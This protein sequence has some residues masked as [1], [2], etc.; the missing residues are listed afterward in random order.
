MSV[1]RR[2]A[3][4]NRLIANHLVAPVATRLPSFGTVHHIGRR[5]GRAYRTPVRAIRHGNQYLISL[6][7][8]A[9]SDWVQNVV[10]AGECHLEIGGVRERL[11]EGTVYVDHEQEHLPRMAR[12][13]L[14]AAR[15][16]DVIALERAEQ[17]GT[18]EANTTEKGAEHVSTG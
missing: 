18:D 15:V 16:T 12:R 2:L 4:F 8:G 17:T 10:A 13:A 11:V 6:P 1:K 3:R 9:E 5:S 7:Y 14:I